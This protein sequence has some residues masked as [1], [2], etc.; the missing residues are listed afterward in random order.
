[1]SGLLIRRAQPE[2]LAVDLTDLKAALRVEHALDDVRLEQLIRS[3]TARYEDFTGRFMRPTDLRLTLDAWCAAV[4]L[5]ALPLREVSEVSYL[6][7][8]DVAQ[9]LAASGWYLTE[10]VPHWSLS[11]DRST[12][13]PALSGRPAAVRIDLSAGYDAPGGA[14]TSLLAPRAEDQ[15]AIIHMVGVA[16]DQGVPM[17]MADMRQVFGN[18]RAVGW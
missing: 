12:A 10:A 1:M 13:L 16:Y 17:A 9:T 7:P 5:P 14:A 6:D 18:R 15:S 4:R 8:S 3:E 2:G 11:F